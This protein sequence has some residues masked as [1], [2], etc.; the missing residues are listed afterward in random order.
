MVRL[1]MVVRI[2]IVIIIISNFY[3]LLDTDNLKAACHV[4]DWPLQ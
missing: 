2:I 3:V 1:E 4:S